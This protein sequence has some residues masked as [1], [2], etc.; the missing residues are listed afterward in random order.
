M[1]H[2]VLLFVFTL[3]PIAGILG[4]N[5]ALNR[6]VDCVEQQY[7]ADNLLI[8]GRPY[9]RSNPRAE[10]HPYFLADEWKPGVAY[11]NGNAFEANEL[12]YNLYTSQ[13]I[14]KY[15][16]PNGI[17]QKVV[18]SDMLVDSFRIAAQIFVRQNEVLTEKEGSGYLEKI[19]E[20]PLSFFRLQRKVF[21]P[22]SGSAYGQFSSQKEV[23]YLLLGDKQ[24]KITRK[25]DFLACF[26]GRK[27]QIKKYMKTHSLKWK[28][29]TNPQ[30]THLLK[31]CYG[32][33]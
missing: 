8:N 24:H 21:G 32:Q 5:T 6:F 1:N 15:E 25:K 22:I 13:L 11:I 23:F 33:I 20:H 26:P 31:F 9:L 28:K 3:L 27:A 19:A 30:F 29:M 7:G 12:K 4:Q 14:L 17:A 16:R 18:L 10:G 2:R